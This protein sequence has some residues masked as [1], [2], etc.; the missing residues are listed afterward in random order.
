MS[1]DMLPAREKLQSPR[2]NL[3]L[4]T[5]QILQFVVWGP[6]DTFSTEIRFLMGTFPRPLTPSVNLMSQHVPQSRVSLLTSN[7]RQP[8]RWS[9]GMGG[10]VFP[11]NGGNASTSTPM[12]ISHPS[13]S[14]GSLS[15]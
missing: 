3:S 15:A 13:P 11:S 7:W 6:R 9:V 12:M 10:M 8:T 5:T 14:L 2:K 1:T 4:P